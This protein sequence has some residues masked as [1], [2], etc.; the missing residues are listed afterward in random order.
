MG[1]RIGSILQ[2]VFQFS[3]IQNLVGKTFIFWSL[4]LLCFL[5]KQNR[6]WCLLFGHFLQFVQIVLHF[7]QLLW[8]LMFFF[9][10]GLINLQMRMLL[11]LFRLLDFLLLFLLSPLEIF[12]GHVC[13]SDSLNVLFILLQ[14]VVFLSIFL[15][16]S[17]STFLMLFSTSTVFIVLFA[18]SIV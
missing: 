8:I 5:R 3:H 7:L 11:T 14:I 9:F 2:H 10:Q 17:L 12:F 6:L 1:V 4:L 18:Q 16:V 13:L 15:V